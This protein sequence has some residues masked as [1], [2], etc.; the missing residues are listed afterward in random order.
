MSHLDNIKFQK[1]VLMHAVF[2]KNNYKHKLQ[3]KPKAVIDRYHEIERETCK[4]DPTNEFFHPNF[5]FV[6]VF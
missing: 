1:Y 5:F 3:L 4:T 2:K 6:V